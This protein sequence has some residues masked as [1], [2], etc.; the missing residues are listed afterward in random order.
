MSTSVTAAAPFSRAVVSAMRKLY[1]RNFEM[2]EIWE[3]YMTADI[4]KRWRIRPGIIPGVG[5]SSINLPEA[6]LTNSKYSS[7]LPSTHYD[8]K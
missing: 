3:A 8:V 7:K 6:I 5:N 2:Q 4:Q 1:V